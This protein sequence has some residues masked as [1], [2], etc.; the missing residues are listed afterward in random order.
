MGMYDTFII[1]ISKGEIIEVQTKD[2]DNCMQVWYLGDTV[3]SGQRMN[4][5]RYIVDE[6]YSGEHKKKWIAIV[7]HLGIF[8]DFSISDSQEEATKVAIIIS[9][10]Y[11]NSDSLA[12]NKLANHLSDKNNLLNKEM[13]HRYCALRKV[14]DIY[15]FLDKDVDEIFMERKYKFLDNGWTKEN[16]GP[17]S[18]R[19]EKLEFILKALMSDIIENYPNYTG[20]Q[21]KEEREIGGF[22]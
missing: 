14:T 21:L 1:E 13:N 12:A 16:P 9:Q 8:I 7:I 4:L 19:E 5:N 2:L 20:K 3:I 10:S 22:Y 17:E 11:V 15:N 18:K 6:I